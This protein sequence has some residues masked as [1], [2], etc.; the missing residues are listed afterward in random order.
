MGHFVKIGQP[1][2]GTFS[3]TLSFNLKCFLP[4]LNFLLIFF[5]PARG[6]SLSDVLL[7]PQAN[8]VE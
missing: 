3:R 6:N 8:T 2:V 4:I 1:G 5:N 7:F